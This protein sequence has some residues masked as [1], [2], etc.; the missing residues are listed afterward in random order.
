MRC[1]WI[2]NIQHISGVLDSTLWA[3]VLEWKVVE[4][5]ST[6]SHAPPWL[7]FLRRTIQ[8]FSRPPFY[9]STNTNSR[10]HSDTAQGPSGDSLEQFMLPSERHICYICQYTEFD[11]DSFLIRLSRFSGPSEKIQAN[12]LLGMAYYGW[13][14][15]SL[16]FPGSNPIM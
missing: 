5:P 13:G 16:F 3:A 12:R 8:A 2:V 11:C 10:A 7:F 4:F 14:L 6:T 1:S 15:L 9:L